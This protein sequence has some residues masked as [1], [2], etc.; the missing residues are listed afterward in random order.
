MG[1]QQGFVFKKSCERSEK[2]KFPFLLLPDKLEKGVD[3][4]EEGEVFVFL[5]S[6]SVIYLI[7]FEAH[8]LKCEHKIA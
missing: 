6:L 4:F 7:P 5:M 3:S 8:G 1:N 2:N